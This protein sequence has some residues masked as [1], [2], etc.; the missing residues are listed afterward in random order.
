M[1]QIPL[2][3]PQSPKSATATELHFKFSSLKPRWE[4]LK[5]RERPCPHSDYTLRARR[6]LSPHVLLP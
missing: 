1:G 2:P 3:G 6:A 5:V 4:A